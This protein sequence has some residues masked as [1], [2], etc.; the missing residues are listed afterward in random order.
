[1]QRAFRY[2]YRES[3]VVGDGVVGCVPLGLHDR[4]LG[5]SR[6]AGTSFGIWFMLASFDG[7]YLVPCHYCRRDAYD[8]VQVADVVGA[9]GAVRA[10]DIGFRIRS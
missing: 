8:A 3:G 10:T 2:S 4:D 7:A 9:R 1:M 5:G 6:T